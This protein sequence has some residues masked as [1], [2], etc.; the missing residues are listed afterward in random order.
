MTLPKTDMNYGQEANC[1]GREPQTRAPPWSSRARAAAA[2]ERAAGARG[3]TAAPAVTPSLASAT[4]LW[5]YSG[6]FETDRRTEVREKSRLNDNTIQAGLPGE[7]WETR[8]QQKHAERKRWIN[9]DRRGRFRHFI[10]LLRPRIRSRSR[11][12]IPLELSG[13]FYSLK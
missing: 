4:E 1:W 12:H 2:R 5:P 10:S 6:S 7:T 8:A 13:V 11:F 9:A 3:A